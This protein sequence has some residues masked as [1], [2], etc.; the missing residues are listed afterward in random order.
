MDQYNFKD[1]EDTSELLFSA[2]NLSVLKAMAMLFAWFSSFPGIS[3]EAFSKLLYLLSNF[4]LPTPNQLPSNYQ[5]AHAIIKEYLVPV[6]VYDCCVN[7]CVLF[8]TCSSGNYKSM[9]VCPVCGEDRYK[10]CTKVARKKFK[11]IPLAP[12]FRRLFKNKEMAKLIQSHQKKF[13]AMVISDLHQSPSW[14]LNYSENGLFKGDPRGLSLA[15]CTDGMN[16][17]AKEKVTYS[18]W[19]IN[20]NLPQ[21]LR[22]TAGLML[23]A[24]IIPGRNE[25]KNLDPYLQLVVDEL[26]SINGSEIYDSYRCELFKLKATITLYVL[27]YP[28]QK[29]IKIGS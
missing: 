7:D 12:H 14:N 9:T 13:K 29:V 27:D 15:L 19:P 25:P 2:S 16:P 23:L 22:I 5:K 20:L 1:K 6:E 24:G 8:R 17:F 21:R 4:L 3:K 10:P 28:G 26:Q 18:M 11:Y